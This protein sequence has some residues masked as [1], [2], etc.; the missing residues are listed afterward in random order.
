LFEKSQ[1]PS[2][3]PVR[4]D[5][6]VE[7]PRN[8]QVLLAVFFVKPHRPGQKSGTFSIFKQALMKGEDFMS[9][10]SQAR[11]TSVE[12]EFDGDAADSASLCP[13]VTV[14]VLGE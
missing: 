8:T 10:E 13:V 2:F 11:R 14:E 9:A 5:L 3:C 7:N 6:C 1:T 4:A 12:V